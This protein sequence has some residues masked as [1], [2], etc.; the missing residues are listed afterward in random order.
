MR[1]SLTSI[2]IFFTIVS[3]ACSIPGAGL[4][5]GAEA[6]L[7]ALSVQTT[8]EAIQRETAAAGG[9]PAGGGDPA[10]VASDTPSS[11]APVVTDTPAPPTATHTPS[12]PQVSVSVNTNCR[13]GPGQAY[14]LL[15]AL[16]VGQTAEV[17]GRNND[18]SY[19]FIRNPSGGSNCW[20]WGQYA[21][22]EGNVGA[23]PVFTP[24]P[25]PTPTFTPTPT[26]LWPGAWTMIAGPGT[27]STTIS[28]TGN[29]I[30]GTISYPGGTVTYTG[31]LSA[32]GKTATGTWTD[33][34]GPGGNFTWF[35]QDN[36]NQFTGNANSG[37]FQWCGYRG[38]SAAPS[39]CLAP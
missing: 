36:G 5:T 27:H 24:P 11:S 3:L 6:T 22:T 21:T 35:L 12:V 23:L 30:S 14:P 13:T 7:Q 28:Q 18:S 34:G 9:Q 38:S 39:P 15:G 32:D 31:T 10:A 19:F 17:L 29:T 26:P 2:F 8:L 33:T 25:T 4:S 37:A 1:K 16:N 20:L